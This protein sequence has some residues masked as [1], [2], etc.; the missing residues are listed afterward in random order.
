MPTDGAT[1]G[2]TDGSTDGATD[3]ATDGAFCKSLSSERRLKIA[4]L[5][6]SS[7]KQKPAIKT[8]SLKSVARSRVSAESEDRQF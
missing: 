8:I 6:R 4:S 7:T 1:N 5:K 3:D 2:A